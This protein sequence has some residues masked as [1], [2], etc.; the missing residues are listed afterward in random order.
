M[1]SMAS[2]WYSQFGI[3]RN[4]LDR[5]SLQ[6]LCTNVHLPDEHISYNVPLF[7]NEMLIVSSIVREILYTLFS[8]VE[9][10]KIWIGV[11]KNYSND[12]I[13]QIQEFFR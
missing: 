8:K 2:N 12:K 5:A 13:F 6:A 1:G 10:M 4:T 9:I 7:I 3:G 11:N